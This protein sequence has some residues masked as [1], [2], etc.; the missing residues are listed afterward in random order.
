[1]VEMLDHHTCQT[2]FQPCCKLSYTFLTFFD[3][4]PLNE[5]AWFYSEVA[6]IQDNTKIISLLQ[7]VEKAYQGWS[8]EN[9]SLEVRFNDSAIQLD[10]E[11]QEV[12]SW[13]IL[14]LVTPPR[15]SYLWLT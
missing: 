12:G 1:M 9:N 10:Q 14:P 4:R 2:S 7:Y 6:S 5:T 8:K 13:K 11:E 15:V 3:Y